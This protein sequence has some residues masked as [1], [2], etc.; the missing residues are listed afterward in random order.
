MPIVSLGMRA[1]SVDLRERV[2]K[3]VKTGQSQRSV[4]KRYDLSRRSVRRYLQ[5]EASGK[6]AADPR[7]GKA[8][9]LGE[10]KC[11]VLRRQVEAHADWTLEQRAEA[12][13]E[14]T[15]ITL[16][17]SALSSYLKRL[18]ITH[19]LGPKAP[20]LI[21]KKEFHSHRAR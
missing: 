6:L 16:K 9:A 8:R 5:R 1:Y 21:L 4:A 11:E 7:P 17:K 10:T 13:A 20:G 15:G 19:K 3:A 2:V 12:L 18:G 14:E